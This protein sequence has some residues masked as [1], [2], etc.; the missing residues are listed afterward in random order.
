[1]FKKKK[2]IYKNSGVQKFWCSRFLVFKNFGAQKFW[3]S[4]ILVFKN[5]IFSIPSIVERASGVPYLDPVYNEVSSG[6]KSS[7]KLAVD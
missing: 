4:K 2:R 1:M 5:R 6:E 3:C 7:V